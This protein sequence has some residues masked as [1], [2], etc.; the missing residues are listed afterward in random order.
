M[1]VTAG[2]LTRRACG[3]SVWIDADAAAR[4]LTSLVQGSHASRGRLPVAPETT[5]V[6]RSRGLTPWWRLNAGPRNS[7][8]SECPASD[9]NN[10]R[11]GNGFQR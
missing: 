7:R 6:C 2:C 9:K 5:K 10:R 8:N 4:C 3:S 1:V 11:N